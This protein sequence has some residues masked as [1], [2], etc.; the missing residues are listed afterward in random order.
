MVILLQQ[1]LVAC[2]HTVVN[3][4]SLRN[5]AVIL[6]ELNY[7]RSHID[8]NSWKNHGETV[9]ASS[10]KKIKEGCLKSNLFKHTCQCE[11]AAEASKAAKRH[12]MRTGCSI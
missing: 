10:C 1:C 9:T 3:A 5:P 6:S 2:L 11:A 4:R 7:Y 12:E 8:V